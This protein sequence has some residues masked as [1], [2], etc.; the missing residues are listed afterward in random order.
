MSRIYTELPCGCL[1]SCDGGGGLIPVCG[2]FN[3]EGIWI[4]SKDCKV[5]EYLKKHKHKGYYCPICH[6]DE[7][8]KEKNERMVK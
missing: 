5:D 4:P 7:Y 1:V 6:P 8:K 2:D 3:E